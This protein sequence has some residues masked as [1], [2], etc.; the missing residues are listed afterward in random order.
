MESK[1]PLLFF[2]YSATTAIAKPIQKMHVIDF[3]VGK[4]K[5]MLHWTATVTVVECE[6][7]AGI[8]LAWLSTQGRTCAIYRYRNNVKWVE[9][10]EQ[11]VDHICLSPLSSE[12]FSFG[13]RCFRLYRKFSQSLTHSSWNSLC[14]KESYFIWPSVSQTVVR[15]PQ[16]VFGFCPCGPLRLNISPKKTEKIKL[17]WIAYHTL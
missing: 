7:A 8:R 15:W 5:G 9:Y 6:V 17:T 10:V 16:V 1:K 4:R 12:E 3:V 2:F 14:N 11:Q 13:Y